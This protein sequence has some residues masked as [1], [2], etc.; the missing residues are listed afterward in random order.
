MSPVVVLLVFCAVMS[1][2]AIARVLL[3]DDRDRVD[4]GTALVVCGITSL[5][6]VWVLFEEELA[7]T[8]GHLSLAVVGVVL[9]GAGLAFIGRYWDGA[10]TNVEST[11][12]QSAAAGQDA[13]PDTATVE[14]ETTERDR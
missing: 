4:V 5:T 13:T 7:S 2:V 1:A 6:G 9:I 11:N 12:G 10:T 8:G 3:E 14:V